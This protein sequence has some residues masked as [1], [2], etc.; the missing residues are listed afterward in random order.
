M[1]ATILVIDDDRFLAGSISKL[2]TGEGHRVRLAHSGQDGLLAIVESVPDLVILD[3]GLG[4]TDGFAVCRQIRAKWRFPII[5]LTARGDLIDRV[6]G[7]EVGA[8]DYLVKPFQPTELTARVRASLRRSTEYAVSD[9]VPRESGIGALVVDQDKRDASMNG[10]WLKLNNKEFQLIS[11]LWANRGRVVS[12]E[13]LFDHNWGYEI[14]FN[15]NSLDVY[16]YRLR[17]K[18]EANPDRPE[19]LHTLRGFGYKLDYLPNR[20]DD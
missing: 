16:I 4:D 9:G 3:V 2:L 17:Q 12:R 11:H 7:L 5:M 20:I 10:S 8:D 1:S 14:S 13:A 19:Y 18:I 15:S 6:V